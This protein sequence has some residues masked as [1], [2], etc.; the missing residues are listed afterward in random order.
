MCLRNITIA[1]LGVIEAA[2][3]KPCPAGLAILLD[4]I[5]LASAIMLST[6]SNQLFFKLS[7][8][9]KDI[10]AKAAQGHYLFAVW[11]SETIRHPLPAMPVY[12]L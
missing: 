12:K 11:Q 2:A 10:N 4:A 6:N 3:G 5:G 9:F 1:S 7:Y 8:K